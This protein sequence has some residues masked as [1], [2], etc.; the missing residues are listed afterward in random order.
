MQ[1][2]VKTTDDEMQVL[3]AEA[4]APSVIPDADGDVMTAEEIRKMAYRFMYKGDTHCVDTQHDR[5]RNG[6]VIVESFIARDGDPVFI[7][8][9]WVVAIWI[10]DLLLWNQIKAGDFRGLSLD[11]SYTYEEVEYEVELP[12]YVEG[13]TTDESGHKHRFRVYFDEEGRFLGGET[14]YVNGHMHR[15]LTGTRT[16]ISAGHEHGFS[17]VEL[18]GD[19]GIVLVS[20]SADLD[21]SEV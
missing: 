1:L 11:F 7:S 13:E 4:Y 6:S 15:I 12:E 10:P 17:F 19:D 16:Q 14:D 18:V 5:V 20:E 2:R 3:Y 21:D 8:G 9:S